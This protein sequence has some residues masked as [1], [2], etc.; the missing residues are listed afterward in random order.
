[1]WYSDEP[2]KPIQHYEN[3]FPYSTQN[4]LNKHE[5]KKTISLL[6]GQVQSGK[7][8]RIIEILKLARK[9]YN[10]DFLFLLGGINQLLNYQSYVRVL[11][12]LEINVFDNFTNKINYPKG[13]IFVVLKED[14]WLTKVNSFVEAN[15]DKKIL[16]I[17][18]ESDYGSINNSKFLSKPST[19]NEE[20]TKIYQSINSS[21]GGMILITA[22]PYANILTRTTENKVNNVWSLPTSNEYTGINFFS[23]VE[24]FYL[25]IPSNFKKNVDSG[26]WDINIEKINLLFSFLVW[27]INS[28]LIEKDETFENKTSDFLIN[29]TDNNDKHENIIRDIQLISSDLRAKKPYIINGFSFVINKLKI[30]NSEINFEKIWKYWVSKKEDQLFLI[31]NQKHRADL[32]IFNTKNI[33]KLRVIVGGKFLSRGVTFEFLTTE[34]FLNVAKRIQIDN[35]MQK[36][37]WFGYRKTNSRFKYMNVVTNFEIMETLNNGALMINKI[38]FPDNNGRFLNFHKL[39]HELNVVID[40]YDLRGSR[41]A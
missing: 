26:I 36:C 39:N 24:N 37:R 2:I 40:R 31:L 33:N 38:F 14:D 34:I 3:D 9:V 16:L 5:N 7:T 11:E 10:Y 4:V 15:S 17:D 32:E 22:T 35:L 13:S 27:V 29:V 20:L 28:Y 1:M 41:N 8:R 19:W 18:D 21:F 12:E 23:N 6:I 30:S 25:D